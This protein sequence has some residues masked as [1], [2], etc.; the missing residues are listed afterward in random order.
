MNP[1]GLFAQVGIVESGVLG[2]CE[3]EAQIII[4]RIEFRELTLDRKGER[5]PFRG[6]EP[7]EVEGTAHLRLMDLL[8][9]QS[10]YGLAVF[11]APSPC[12]GIGKPPSLR[13]I[14]RADGIGGEQEMGG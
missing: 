12:G 8:S 4:A 10:E 14:E 13:R 9:F 2:A 6:L 1:V 5:F 11:F 3:G 7:R